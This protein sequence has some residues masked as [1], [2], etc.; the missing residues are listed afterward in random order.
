MDCR[1]HPHLIRHN[2]RKGFFIGYGIYIAD[3]DK[4]LVG[5][6]YPCEKIAEKR[7]RRIGNDNVG[8]VAQGCDFIALKIAVAI[9]IIPL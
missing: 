9:K 4:L 8:L 1:T 7:E 2:Q 6:G 5:F 3:D